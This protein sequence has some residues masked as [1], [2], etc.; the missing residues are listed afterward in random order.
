MSRRALF[1]PRVVMSERPHLVITKVPTDSPE[2]FFESAL[3]PAEARRLAT[4]LL[5][6]ADRAERFSET[7]RWLQ[8]HQK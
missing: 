5:I 7:Q 2:T 1:L 3:T 6:D 4:D 8:K